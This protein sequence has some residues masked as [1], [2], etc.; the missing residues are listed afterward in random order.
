MIC[1][2]TA[3]RYEDSMLPV[4]S[5]ETEPALDLGLGYSKGINDLLSMES[6]P[7]LLYNPSDLSDYLFSHD[8]ALTLPIGEGPDWNLGTGKAATAPPSL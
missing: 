6:D 2:G 5:T 8:T 7:T 1:A 4:H 3:L